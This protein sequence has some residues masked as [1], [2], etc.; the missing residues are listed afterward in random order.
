[1]LQ[2]SA[3]VYGRLSGDVTLEGL[4]P[5]G[6]WSGRAPVD[7]ASY[8]LVTFN[9]LPGRT[10]YTFAGPYRFV[11]DLRITVLDRSEADEAVGAASDRILALLQ[12]ASDAALPMANFDVLYLRRQTSTKMAPV[13][14]GEQFQQLIDGY[15][16]EVRPG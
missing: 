7:V 12:D 1:M 6:V 13:R 5:G 10:D 8:P 4:A 9:V 3:A 16:L 11:F 2:A 14:E 15:R